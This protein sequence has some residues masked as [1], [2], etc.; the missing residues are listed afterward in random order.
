MLGVEHWTRV[1]FY[2]QSPVVGVTNVRGDWYSDSRLELISVLFDWYKQR[3]KLFQKWTQHRDGSYYGLPYLACRVLVMFCTTQRPQPVAYGLNCIFAFAEKRI[4]A[5][6]P[7][8]LDLPYTVQLTLLEGRC[9]T[10][11]AL[12]SACSLL[13]IRFNWV[14]RVSALHWLDGY[15]E[16]Q[17]SWWTQEQ[18]VYT[19]YKDSKKTFFGSRSHKNK[20]LRLLMWTFLLFA[21]RLGQ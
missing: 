19:D 18:G 5:A 7:K 12:F 20:I 9:V 14:L 13:H 17:Q 10:K 3:N 6:R 8:R 15:K 2:S 11:L 16:A 1:L 4:P 21:A